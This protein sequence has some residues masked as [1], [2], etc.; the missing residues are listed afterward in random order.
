MPRQDTSND[1]PATDRSQRL[2]DDHDG[3]VVGKDSDGPLE[4]LGKAIVAPVAGADGD[5]E[6]PAGTGPAPRPD[7]VPGGAPGSQ[8]P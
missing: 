5:A 4:S 3:R 6:K 1:R 7:P 2:P 8:R